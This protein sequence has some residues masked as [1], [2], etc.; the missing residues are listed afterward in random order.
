MSAPGALPHDLGVERL[1]L[2]A[3]LMGDTDACEESRALGENDFYD[4]FHQRVF[5]ACRELI[6]RD[7]KPDT[8]LVRGALLLAQRMP[9]GGEER[10]LELSN[11]VMIGEP[12]SFIDRLRE[13]T[14]A[15]MVVETSA[16]IAALGRSGITNL[17]EFLDEAQ[18][19]LLAACESRGDSV[20]VAS[21]A[22][23]IN[24]AFAEL[25]LR[26]RTPGR[27]LGKSTGLTRLDQQTGGMCGGEVW[28]VAGRPGMGKSAFAQLIARTVAE[29]GDPALIFSLEM[30]PVMWAQRLLGAGA[31]ANIQSVRTGEC[32]LGDDWAKLSDEAH[33]LAGLPI[34]LPQT[35]SATPLSLRRVARRLHS[36]KPLGLIV[37]DYVQLVRGDRKT[38]SRE[39]EV[40]E[41][42]RST[43]LLAGE[44]DVPVLV[45]AQL[46]RNC[47]SRADKRPMLSDLRESGS[48]EQD[49]DVVLMLYRDELY[50]EGSR[51]KGV[52]EVG[53]AK[54]RN[55]PV[56]VVPV[57]FTARYTRFGNL[58]EH[59]ERQFDNEAAE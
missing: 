23:V 7:Q 57:A 29:S 17:G 54:Q 25:E 59:Q 48:I 52:C 24:E 41:V 9:P 58:E 44:L 49:S 10:I 6:G 53:I 27:L 37:I 30:A 56:G 16:R 33:R 20:V 18:S 32:L 35:L 36:K 42:M 34:F 8:T 31:P 2:A 38:D 26:S 13:L 1:L 39:Q 45:L 12:E 51:H 46:N 28:T 3:L 40:S 21:M 15:R 4:I 55:G 47:E 5:A 11:T 43:K 19:K 14:T 22:D 50:N